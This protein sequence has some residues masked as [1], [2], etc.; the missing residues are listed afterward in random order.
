M[1]NKKS[2]YKEYCLEEIVNQSK[3]VKHCEKQRNQTKLYQVASDLQS[4]K[5]E[6]KKTRNMGMLWKTATKPSPVIITRD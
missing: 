6:K 1:Q 5:W 2:W 3:L 4:N